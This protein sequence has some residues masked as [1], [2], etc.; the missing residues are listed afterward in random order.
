MLELVMTA[1]D[2]VFDHDYRERD[3]KLMIKLSKKHGGLVAAKIDSS[4]MC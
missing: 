2:L 1:G 3:L 4:M